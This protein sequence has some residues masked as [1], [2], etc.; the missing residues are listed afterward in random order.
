MNKKF[1]AEKRA[2]LDIPENWSNDM[3]MEMYE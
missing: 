2:K 3:V 1:I